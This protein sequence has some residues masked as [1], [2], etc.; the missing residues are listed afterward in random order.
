[1]QL[2]L[3]SGSYRT[4]LKFTA[5]VHSLTPPGRCVL[6]AEVTTLYGQIA[7]EK[8]NKAR[9]QATCPWALSRTPTAGAQHHVGTRAEGVGYLRVSAFGRLEQRPGPACSPGSVAS[10]AGPEQRWRCSKGLQ[11]CSLRQ[12]VKPVPTCSRHSPNQKA[13]K[14]PSAHPSCVH[15]PNIYWVER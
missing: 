8:R 12:P 5:E 3:F 15:P 10:Q 2:H 6:F 7:G 4:F 13:I 14:P 9:T 1:M 11:T